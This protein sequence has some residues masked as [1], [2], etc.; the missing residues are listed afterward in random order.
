MSFENKLTTFLRMDGKGK[1]SE[2]ILNDIIW[3]YKSHLY[4][5]T[6][7]I[8]I[9]IRLRVNSLKMKY[10]SMLQNVQCIYEY[11]LEDCSPNLHNGVLEAAWMR[12]VVRKVNYLSPTI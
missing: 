12:D 3:C 6:I 11:A 7:F 9:C 5:S 8:Y 1:I 2:I 10:F 4:H